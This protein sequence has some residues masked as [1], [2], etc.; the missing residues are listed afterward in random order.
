M[1]SSFDYPQKGDTFVRQLSSL[2]MPRSASDSDSDGENESSLGLVMER[3]AASSTVSLESTERLDAL[4]KANAELGRKL[5]EAERTLENRL[6]EH[7]MDLD[8]MQ[9]R[10]EE[11]KSE[12]TSTK[13]EEKELRTKERTNS[14]QIAALESEIAKLEKSLENARSSYQSLQKQYQEQCAESERY[15]NQLRRR[16]QEIKDYKDA[17][18]L[19]SLEAVKWAKEASSYEDRLAHLEEELAIAQQAHAQLD[20]QK[21]ENLMLKET[22]DRMRFDLDEMRSAA[23]HAA[24]GS[25]HS[26]AANTMS[27]SLGAELMGKMGDSWGGENDGLEDEGDSDGLEL[28]MDEDTED[29]EDVIQT[30]IT[31]K[32][33][34]VGRVNKAETVTFS[35]TKT[36]VDTSTQH[37]AAEHT[38]ACAMQTDPEPKVFTSSSSI[39]TEEVFR[40][41]IAIQTD[42]ELPRI[43]TSIEIQTDEP[44]QAVSRSVSPLVTPEDDE[45]LASSSST[46]LPP[47]PKGHMDSPH[48]TDAPPSYNFVTELEQVNNALMDRHKGITMPI[49]GIPGGISAD[50]VEEWKALKEELGVECEM[51]DE[52]IACSTTKRQPRRQ[53]RFYKIYNTY[54]IGKGGNERG[55][56]GDAWLAGAARQAL[57]SAGA[58]ALV[59]LCMTSRLPAI[60]AQYS[61]VGGPTVY[62]R[63]AW[64]SFN[65]MQGPGEGFGY[66]GTSAVWNI[67]GRVGF[68]AARIAGG[69]P[70]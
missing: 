66:D 25:G 33:R 7:D 16:D 37:N 30:I 32:K 47:T 23:T 63:A 35:E 62:D 40:G 17:A 34:K 29:E 12:L 38:L 42:P 48:L 65:S 22:I 14:T 43:T 36:Y 15:R 53:N 57:I 56:E 26:S 2:P 1:D 8:E 54:V 46:V 11:L 5:I 41:I 69:W 60:G 27:K 19:Q 13:R 51:I 28:D 58:M 39:Q 59:F 9:G 45:T 3:S 31:R 55:D 61:P 6:N 49:R 10:L 21:Q 70:T 68:G 24:A 18:A 64:S 20:E 44:E 50:A 67:M 52:L 4:Q